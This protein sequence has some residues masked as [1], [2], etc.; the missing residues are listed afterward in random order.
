MKLIK[1]NWYI[2]FIIIFLFFLSFA[3]LQN[4]K[5]AN[6]TFKKGINRI[7]LLH[8]QNLAHLPDSI[9]PNRQVYVNDL[10]N[11]YKQFDR[12]KENI[13]D[14]NTL[15]FL[16]QMLFIF[17][18]GII[19]YLFKNLDERIKEISKGLIDKSSELIETKYKKYK[20]NNDLLF[21]CHILNTMVLNIIPKEEYYQD[22]LRNSFFIM[23]YSERLIKTILKYQDEE[24]EPED[25]VFASDLLSTAIHNF[26]KFVVFSGSND[27]FVVIQKK[28]EEALAMVEKIKTEG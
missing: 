15:S 9:Q 26:E 24:I 23:D 20:L 13:I 5:N 1:N 28:I 2:F 7:V 22:N 21:F 10:E 6:S 8:E 18:V 12:L 4:T 16:Y 25:K 19:L 27:Y 14:S 11:C 17:V 3:A